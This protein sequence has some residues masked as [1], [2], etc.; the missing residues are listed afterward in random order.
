[1]AAPGGKYFIQDKLAQSAEHHASFEALWKTKWKPLVSG[2][3]P[4]LARTD[5]KKKRK[6]EIAPPSTRWLTLTQ[7]AAIHQCDK[8]V[9]P[10]MFGTTADFE[11]VAKKMIAAGLKP[12]YDWDEYASYF[13]VQA[14]RLVVRAASSYEKEKASELF[15]Y[16]II[17]LIL[18]FSFSSRISFKHY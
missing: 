6:R 4:R 3:L 16:V 15:L 9:Y 10:F 13:L 17:F 2:K 11:P 14:H 7:L 18:P 5:K 8:G 12:P 1:M